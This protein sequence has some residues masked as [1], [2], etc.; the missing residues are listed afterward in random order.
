MPFDHSPPPSYWPIFLSLAFPLI[1]RYGVIGL[2]LSFGIAYLISAALA[3]LVL[4][5]KVS[6]FSLRASS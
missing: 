2:G 1:D 5:Y 3:L 4:S 6:G